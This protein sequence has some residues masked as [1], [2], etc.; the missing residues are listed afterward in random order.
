MKQEGDSVVI[1]YAF[2]NIFNKD[3]KNPLLVKYKLLTEAKEVLSITDTV[4]KVLMPDSTLKFKK[5]FN[6]TGH[7]G[8]NVLEV[9]VNP[10]NQPEQLFDNNRWVIPF[11]VVGDKQN[12]LLDVYFDGVRI[13]NGDVVSPNPDIQIVLKDENKFLIKKDTI[14]M[15]IYIKKCETCDY[16]RILFSNPDLLINYPSSSNNNRLS[17]N[18]YPKNLPDGK[19][20]LRV[21]G[22][23]ASNNISGLQPYQI[24][25]EVINKSSVSNFYPYPNPFSSATRFVYTLTGGLIPD[26]VK[27]QILTATGK[28]VREV[29]QNEIGQLRVGTHQTDFVWNGTDEFGDKLANGVYLYRVILKV[30]GQNIDL[31]KTAG[32]KAFNDGWGKMYILR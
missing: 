9:F 1:N 25:F 31:R 3:F 10:L 2:S 7:V 15:S 6:T 13:M 27:I 18:Y 19:Y 12:P 32:D 24:V 21:Q 11:G 30:N 16:E 28:V 29:S 23:D 22:A 5:V 17:I 14:G 20:T 4:Y 8:N 26:E